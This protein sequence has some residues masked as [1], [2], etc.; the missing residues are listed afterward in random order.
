MVVYLVVL[1]LPCASLQ[2]TFKPAI[3]SVIHRVIYSVGSQS[4]SEFN[5]QSE[6]KCDL[7]SESAKRNSKKF[8]LF[9]D[10]FEL[11]SPS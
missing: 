11:I 8:F 1:S 6:S 10:L 9:K 7:Q 2:I 3:Y 4:D 5:S